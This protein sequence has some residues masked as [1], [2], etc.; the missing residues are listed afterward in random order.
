MSAMQV[1]STPIAEAHKLVLANEA[2]RC[3]SQVEE[4]KAQVFWF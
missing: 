2:L 4:P 3:R 1:F